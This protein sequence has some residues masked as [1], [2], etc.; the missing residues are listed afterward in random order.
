[1]N[2]GSVVNREPVRKN[3][4]NL[5]SGRFHGP[6]KRADSDLTALLTSIILVV[7]HGSWTPRGLYGKSMLEEAINEI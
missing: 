2:M 3:I 4:Q 1:M 6:P 7:S 5:R